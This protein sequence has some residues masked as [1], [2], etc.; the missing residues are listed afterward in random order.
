[1]LPQQKAE[2]YDS[3][4][5]QDPK[6]DT[7]KALF[8]GVILS[9]SMSASAIDTVVGGDFTCSDLQA[10]LQSAGQLYIR[11]YFGSHLYQASSKCDKWNQESYAAYDQSAD[12]DWCRLGYVCKTHH[13]KDN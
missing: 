8:L 11:G 6:G 12:T 5:K 2:T 9:A 13:E 4:H 10:Q 1:M 3:E 7:M